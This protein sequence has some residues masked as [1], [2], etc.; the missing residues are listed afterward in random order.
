MTKFEESIVNEHLNHA[1]SQFC[2]ATPELLLSIKGPF[3]Y[4]IRP[5]NTPQSEWVGLVILG[6]IGLKPDLHSHRVYPHG[7][8]Y[9]GIWHFPAST[10]FTGNGE[11]EHVTEYAVMEAPG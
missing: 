7:Y 2:P 5:V 9:N 4:K 6:S 10:L 8:W 11:L 1:K 3:W